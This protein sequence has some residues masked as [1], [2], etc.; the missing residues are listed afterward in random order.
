MPAP[1]RRP[2]RSAGIRRVQ[3]VAGTVGF[4]GGAHGLQLAAQA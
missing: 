2:D 4:E 3:V 1:A